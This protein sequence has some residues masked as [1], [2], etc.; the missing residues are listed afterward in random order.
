MSVRKVWIFV[1]Y[2][3]FAMIH[4]VHTPVSAAVDMKEM[5]TTAQ[6]RFPYQNEKKLYTKPLR[7]FLQYNHLQILMNVIWLQ[8]I[9]TT[10]PL[11]LT[12]MG[13]ITALATLAMREMES[14]A[15][16]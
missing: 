13:A 1:M 4:S 7:L 12:M 2:M 15:Q 8:M 3:L 6:V 11:A 16:V 5:E 9:A 10:M 14:T